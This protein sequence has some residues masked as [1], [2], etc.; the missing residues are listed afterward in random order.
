MFKDND[1]TTTERKLSLG[2]EDREA[3]MEMLQ[4]D[5]DYLASHKLMDY[6]LM[7]GIRD[8]PSE[9]ELFRPG[10]D[11]YVFAQPLR[12]PD[13]GPAVI[14]SVYLMGIVNVLT[15]YDLKKSAAHTA[16]TTFKKGGKSKTDELSG[17]GGITTVNP[18]HYRDRFVKFIGS[19]LEPGLG[20]P[21]GQH[22]GPASPAKSPPPRASSPRQLEEVRTATGSP[23]VSDEAAR[24][25]SPT[26]PAVTFL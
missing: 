19:I 1:F 11:S 3:F 5:A 8:D 24:A 20:M 26:Q 25:P 21:E 17:G 18:E 6:S 2:G 7:V 16:K 4:R 13:S 9:P 15:K 22:T 12:D 14:G 10:R 23:T